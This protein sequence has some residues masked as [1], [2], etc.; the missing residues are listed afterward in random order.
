ME[1]YFWRALTFVYVCHAPE[2]QPEARVACGMGGV[3]KMAAATPAATP[4]KQAKCL[5]CLD[6][7]PWRVFVH[8]GRK[9]KNEHL[10]MK[11]K[12]LYGNGDIS[13]CLQAHSIGICHSCLLKINSSY[14]M[15]KALQD[16]IHRL[17]QCKR[18]AESGSEKHASPRR[19]RK[20]CQ[21][22][23]DMPL[24]CPSDMCNDL[25]LPSLQ[26]STL[27][28]MLGTESLAERES[29][30]ATTET[31]VS[32][33]NPS[34][35]LPLFKTNTSQPK[36]KMLISQE[37]H[38]YSIPSDK[39]QKQDYDNSSLLADKGLQWNSQYYGLPDLSGN[40][41]TVLT[42]AIGSGSIETLVN[43][44]IHVIPL[45]QGLKRKILE[46]CQAACVELTS[47]KKPSVLREKRRISSLQNCDLPILCV[48]EMNSRY[49]NHR[50]IHHVQIPYSM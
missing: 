5:G 44:I 20:K 23:I 42:A 21:K 28:T 48:K 22:I 9:W 43:T 37:I 12:H 24:P 11:L 8:R 36:E 3:F 17:S 7:N 38:S 15:V 4:L 6:I 46:E 50:N 14:D 35:S 47:L 25:P 34:I 29:S 31:N 30:S 39:Y 27:D 16:N 32:L 13:E 49:V 45:Y 41:I 26:T 18:E 40:D 33:C 10:D 19:R 1:L 2:S